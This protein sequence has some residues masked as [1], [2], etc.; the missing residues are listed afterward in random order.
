MLSI[1]Q[2]RDKRAAK[3]K[4]ARKILNDA[5][6][7]G[8]SQETQ[9]A[10]D[11]LYAEIE[12]IDGSIAAINKQLKIEGGEDDEE[13]AAAEGDEEE[14]AVAE[15]DDEEDVQAKARRRKES[16]FARKHS[17]VFAKWLRGGT[18][19]LSVADFDIIRRNP[20]GDQSVGDGQKGGYTAPREFNTTL[21]ERL[22]DFGGVRELATIMST[23]NGNPIDWPTVDETNE[24]GEIVAESQSAADSDINFGTVS[25]G[26]HKYSSKVIAVPIELLQDTAINLEGY[27]ATALATRIARINNRH[28][29]NG[30]GVN[31][32]YGLVS[33]AATGKTTAV[34][35][36]IAFEEI[37]DLEH[38]IDPAYRRA[39]GVGFMFHDNT[40]KVLKKMKD[41]DDRPLWLP[42][43]GVKEPDTF[44]G[45]RYA[46]NQHM[47]SALTPA[48]R[49]MVFGD[50]SKYI[51]RDVM[52]VQ[53]LRFDDSA[54]A[55]K[56]QV[57][58]LA[59]MRTDG[60]RIDASSDAYKVMVQGA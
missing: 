14:E 22:K 45:Y 47:D 30:T 44:L 53:L 12:R 4:E 17:S 60:R 5:G 38:S 36:A 49:S 31:Q 1:Q 10:I 7:G 6:E 11:A 40:L 19:N 2:L 16:A 51:I 15:G 57:G 25:I 48:A 59:F 8:L 55:R 52:A 21:L 35:D 56:G 24:E 43:L 18:A 13:G 26:A 34:D 39:S 33:K 32:P 54:F 27:I 46:I 9:D 50:F 41:G 23:S 28:F 29:T 20:R 3:A 37:I 42:G 58:F